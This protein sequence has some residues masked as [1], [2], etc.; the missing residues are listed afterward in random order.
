M[1]IDLVQELGHPADACARAFADPG[2]YPWF[3]K[4]PKV[5]VPEVLAREVDGDRVRLRIRYRF[6][7]D[8]NAAVRA[9]IDPAK[10]TWV[11]ESQHDLVRHH[12]TFVLRP[13]HYDRQ[14]KGRGE[15]RFID[16]AD[17]CRREAGI[18]IKVSFPIVGRAVEAAIASGLREHLAD[19]VRIVEAYL[20]ATA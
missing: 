10:L 6:G 4:L 13:D 20:A 2:L 16:T 14:F 17:G 9:V 8:V 11:D 5:Q 15:Y 19:E 18:D 1:R 3:A 7:G 12:V